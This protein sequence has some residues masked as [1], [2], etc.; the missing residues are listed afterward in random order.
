VRDW[1]TKLEKWVSAWDQLSEL[2]KDCFPVRRPVARDDEN[3]WPADL[4][5]CPTLVDF[6]SR[7]DGG[8]FGSYTLLPLAEV[9]DPSTGWLADSPGLEVKA[10]RWIQFGDHEFGHALLWDADADEVVLYSPD[11]EEPRRLK[12]TMLQFI[13]RL[14]Y[15]SKKTTEDEDDESNEMWIEALEEAGLV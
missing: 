11:D 2:T 15:P 1:K 9:D 3:N 13:E 8:R 6:Y 12:R 4:P 5:R 10:G 14:L 7:C